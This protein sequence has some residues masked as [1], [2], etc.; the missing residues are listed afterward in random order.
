MARIFMEDI[1]EFIQNCNSDEDLQELSTKAWGRI[2]E[3]QA[4][5]ANVTRRAI[6][7]GDEV[8]LENFLGKNS[9][10]NGV[11]VRVDI[12]RVSK[13]SVMLLEPVSHGRKFWPKGAMVRVQMSN[14]STQGRI[15]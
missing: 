13:V 12:I 14:I 4:K 6:Q 2:K 5:R 11:R 7:E 15:C 8:T 1:E 9:W 10:L 3:I